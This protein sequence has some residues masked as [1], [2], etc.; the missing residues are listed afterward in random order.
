[1]TSLNV[2]F[3]KTILL[4]ILTENVNH[5]KC[6]LTKKDIK[7]NLCD[8]CLIR[9]LVIRSRSSKGRNSIKPVEF[10]GMQ[11]EEISFLEIFNR[12]KDLCP[13]VY[14]KVID[15]WGCQTCSISHKDIALNF[16]DIR[17]RGKDVHLLLTSWEKCYLKKH[18]HHENLTNKKAEIFFFQCDYGALLNSFPN[19]HVNFAICI[20]E[21][22]I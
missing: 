5:D 18:M 2:N 13:D 17:A 11:K 1:M 15:D 4:D 6:C 10:L 8:F 16:S 22:S 12:I 9:S 21:W 19:I 20:L 14:D 3:S 7:K